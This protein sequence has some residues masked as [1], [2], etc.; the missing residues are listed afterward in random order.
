MDRPSC[1]RLA[2]V[3][4]KLGVQLRVRWEKL[5]ARVYQRK[6]DSMLTVACVVLDKSPPRRLAVDCGRLD[7]VG[8]TT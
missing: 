3:L 1:H 5:L 7:T 8:K 2:S 4:R 6:S